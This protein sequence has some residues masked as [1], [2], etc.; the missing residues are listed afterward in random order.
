M[1]DVNQI[2]EQIR[3]QVQQF[4]ITLAKIVTKQEQTERDISDIKEAVNELKDKPSKRW[5]SLVAAIIG[6][7]VTAFAAYIIHVNNGG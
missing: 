2:V 3:E 1:P 4:A 5:D 6:A 7:A